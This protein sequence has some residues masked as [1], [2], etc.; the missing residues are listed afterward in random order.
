MSQRANKHNTLTSANSQEVDYGFDNGLRVQR[1]VVLSPG[2]NDQSGELSRPDDQRQ[3]ATPDGMQQL[4]SLPYQER[5]VDD[6]REQ[7]ENPRHICT[8][9]GAVVEA[10]I[11]SGNPDSKSISGV[12]YGW[13]G[14][15]RH[16]HAQQEAMA[17]AWADPDR[18]LVFFNGPS[19]GNSGNLPK[20]AQREI[21]KTGSYLP[22]GEYLSPVMQ[23]KGKIMMKLTQRAFTGG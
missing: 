2:D 15:F 11:V 5:F 23:H 16:P 6:I 21:A 19:I 10:A 18:A 14:N 1:L 17:L 22:L 13:G 9:G 7:L 12:Y 20:S 4:T 8:I 3:I